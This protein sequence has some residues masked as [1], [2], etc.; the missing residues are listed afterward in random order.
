MTPTMTFDPL[1]T[2]RQIREMIKRSNDQELLKLLLA[3][4]RD[5]FALE[6]DNLTLNVELASLKRELA[7]REKMQMRP[8]YGYYFRDGDDVPFC[9][10]CWE[11]QGHVIHL[12][13]PEHFDCGI[14]R[15]CRACRETYWEESIGGKAKAGAA[16]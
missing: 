16:G 9:P 7:L 8:P 12:S 15:E 2:L 10:A 5:I 3:L 13:A 1:N 11:N 6:S 14:R 4:Q